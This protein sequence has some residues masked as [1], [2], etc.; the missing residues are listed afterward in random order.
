MCKQRAKK[1][2]IFQSRDAGWQKSVFFSG[3][4]TVPHGGRNSEEW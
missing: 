4:T 1:I 3:K 2:T